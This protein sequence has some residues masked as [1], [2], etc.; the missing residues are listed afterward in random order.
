M[1]WRHVLGDGAIN[2]GDNDSV[3]PVPQVDCALAAAGALVLGGD[4]K[5]HIVGAFFQFQTGLVTQGTL[6]KHLGG[7]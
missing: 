6:L 7:P 2:V 5:R 4:A 3:V 1:T